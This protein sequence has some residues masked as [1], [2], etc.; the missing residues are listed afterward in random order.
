MNNII[1]VQVI[2]SFEN[3]SDRLRGVFF[4]KL[5]IFTN[6]IKEL[7]TSSELSN[8]VVF[9]LRANLSVSTHVKTTLAVP[10]TRTSREI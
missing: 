7:S 5:A 9:V 6:P 2:D 10:L 8:N 3:L 4:G 1:V